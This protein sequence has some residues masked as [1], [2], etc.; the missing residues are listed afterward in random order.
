[1]LK[2]SQLR[3]SLEEPE[4]LLPELAAAKL[5][6][7]AAKIRGWQILQKNIDARNKADVHFVYSLGLELGRKTEQGLLANPRRRNIQPWAETAEP[8]PPTVCFDPPPLVIGA[9]PA[10]L[11]AALTLAK[12]GARPLVLERGAAVKERSRLV[13]EFWQSGRL[14][15]QTNVQFGEGGAGAFSDG[16]L[17][18]NTK[19]PRN[20]LILQEL[21]AAGAPAEI[22]YLAR[23]HIGTDIL[24]QVVCKLR[25]K[26][27]ELG[28]EVR[29]GQ[30][31]TELV[32]Q[33]G[34]LIAAQVE[35]P[36][37]CRTIPC[38]NLILATGHSAR[39]T[40]AM[41]HRLGVPM[42]PKPFAVGV[43]IEHRQADIDRSQYGDFAG[44]PR[45]SPADY[46]L[47][48][49]LANGRSLFSFCMCPGGQVVA[50]ASETGGVVTNGMS[51]H[52]RAG[53]NANAALL[54]NVTPAD[55]PGGPLAGIELQRK[56]EQA[57]FKM[58]GENY[59]APCQQVGDFLNKQIS[60][61]FG[62]VQPSYRPGVALCD[63]NKLL[64]D[65]VSETLH[66]GLPKLA[67]KLAA[68]CDPEA[69]LTAP[70]TRSSSPVRIIRDSQTGQS[71]GL[72]GLYPC[73]E[74]AGYAGGI[75]SAAADG[76]RMAEA[77]LRNN[78]I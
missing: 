6:I 16:K 26:I 3:L 45:L 15:E 13:A 49:H 59:A 56:I 53:E 54:V 73:G 67:E 18:T 14:L 78:S 4:E 29:F 34:K 62:R 41:L 17:T 50:A 40:F 58:A 7:P 37:G 61:G 10:G 71:P 74:G 43:R 70:E 8:T 22:L 76:M 68:F 48:V 19:D 27:G 9:G 31:L 72:G 30:R 12:A 39:D 64:P 24:R 33:G 2:I 52:A 44:H 77:M 55:F 38:R 46:K 36:E 11:F 60:S 28:G 65:F 66:L 57:A 21:A 42:E 5:H 47:A 69:L 23:P 63:L 75:V 1:M 32:C 20:R 25:Q 51:L 35:G